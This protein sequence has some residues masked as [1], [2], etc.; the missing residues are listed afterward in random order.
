M[1]ITILMIPAI[2]LPDALFATGE[3]MSMGPG[4]SKFIEFIRILLYSQAIK[5]AVLKPVDA[6]KECLCGG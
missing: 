5:N 6:P 3:F 4:N 1:K 2:R